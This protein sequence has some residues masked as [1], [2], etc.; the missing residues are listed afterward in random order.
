MRKGIRFAAVA[1][2][3]S[4]PMASCSCND[5]GTSSAPPEITFPDAE[6]WRSFGK[7]CN[8]SINDQ[9]FHIQ[10]TGRSVLHAKLSLT[11]PDAAFFVVDPAEVTVGS[12]GSVPV[13]V[14]YRPTGDVFGND[15]VATLVV[16]SDARLEP[17]KTFD[18]S[19]Q[20]S[21]VPVEPKLAID[22]GD[23]LPSC[24]GSDGAACCRTEN[25]LDFGD[26]EL[27]T[28]A[29]LP[30]RIS[31]LGCSPLHVSEVRV[32]KL[33]GD[34]CRLV[35]DLEGGGEKEQVL[36]DQF[37]P[38][39]I[40]GSPD[41]TVERPSQEIRFVFTPVDGPCTVDRKFVLVSDDP[42]AP[43]DAAGDPEIGPA[44]GTLGGFGVE[45]A[46]IIT[47]SP[48]VFRD[49]PKGESK[50]IDFTIRNS[51]NDPLT[52][53]DIHVVPS[54]VSG[55]THPEYFAVESITR[56][57]DPVT[58]PGLEIAKASFK[59]EGPPDESHECNDRV[60][61]T[62]RYAPLTA[63][64]HAATVRVETTTGAGASVNINGASEPKLVAYP[65][66]LISFAIPSLAG[67][68][69]PDD[70]SCPATPCAA[71]CSVDEDCPGAK[72]LDGMCSDGGPTCVGVCQSA[73]RSLKICNEGIGDLE[74]GTI[75]NVLDSNGNEP[76]DPQN[77]DA[78]LFT[79]DD[80]C[81]NSTLAPGECCVDTV[82]F[83]DPIVGGTRNGTINIES[84]DATYP[85]GK[86][87]SV[88]STTND[89]VNPVNRNPQAFITG[90][91]GF[92]VVETWI[93]LDASASTTD[94]GGI[95]HFEWEIFDV[96]SS[97]T[98]I[99]KGTDGT[100]DGD[101]IIDPANPNQHCDPGVNG[102]ECIRLSGDKNEILELWPNVA[103]VHYVF[104]V[105][106]VSD[107]CGNIPR[108]LSA[109]YDVQPSNPTN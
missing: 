73:M 45:G 31:N 102:G 23:G 24:I 38:L 15:Q 14:S 59:L 9:V 78:F 108:G 52:I 29:A 40:P 105:T 49:V 32:E 4:L 53:D 17:H 58:V 44:A 93:K 82:T 80:P 101:G 86:T 76:V 8:E 71:A 35:P 51:G 19:A 22:C 46:L 1:A 81:E 20:V 83:L 109:P 85:D 37:S 63:G 94:V 42:S 75:T 26:V 5:G 98:N 74:L 95:D 54:Q 77:D 88:V 34:T 100:N 79:M 66:D 2:L 27:D 68:A 47:P 64:R 10:N 55:G 103:G 69:A 104:K 89:E 60:H 39:T 67:C 18:L 106:A 92:P 65:G 107:I 6:G 72:C 13:T 30:V 70:L 7:V 50:V 96:S 99:K 43:P 41:D 87:I 57:E 21:T 33:G 36:L 25:T 3:L 91:T 97:A 61:F 84:N 48:G 16:D 56:C 28:Q 12:G 90:P 62:V 11:G